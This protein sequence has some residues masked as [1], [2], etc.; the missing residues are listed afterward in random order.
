MMNRSVQH[1]CVQGAMPDLAE[2]LQLMEDDETEQIRDPEITE[3]REIRSQED[4]TDPQLR[5][6]NVQDPLSRRWSRRT[7][8]DN[9]YRVLSLFTWRF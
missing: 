9:T 8:R 7:I 1:G 4:K 6:R 2:L 3:N 5:K